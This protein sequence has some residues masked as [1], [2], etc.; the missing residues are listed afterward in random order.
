MQSSKDEHS[1]QRQKQGQ[2]TWDTWGIIGHKEAKETGA[3]GG[4]LQT[5]GVGAH[6]WV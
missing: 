4:R 5:M 6:V 3:P 2:W 1:Q